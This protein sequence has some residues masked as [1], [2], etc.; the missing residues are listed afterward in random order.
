MGVGGRGLA[1][2]PAANSVKVN[3]CPV[4]ALSVF[5]VRAASAWRPCGAIETSAF[6]NE[7]AVVRRR[8]SSIF[9]GRI[10]PP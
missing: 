1:G 3:F 2:S 7:R 6:E 8:A 10:L 9:Q 5:R 4:A